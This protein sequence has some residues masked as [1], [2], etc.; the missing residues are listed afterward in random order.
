MVV[1]Q[2]CL[3]IYADTRHHRHRSPELRPQLSFSESGKRSEL[4]S[5]LPEWPKW[6]TFCASLCASLCRAAAAWLN[7]R[8]VRAKDCVTWRSGLKQRNEDTHFLI[9]FV[10]IVIEILNLYILNI[11]PR[12]QNGL[13]SFSACNVGLLQ[14]ALEAWAT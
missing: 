8:S 4:V 1:K 3:W 13:Q 12:I 14:E 9:E 10:Y 7:C 11:Q 6:P 2:A 5:S